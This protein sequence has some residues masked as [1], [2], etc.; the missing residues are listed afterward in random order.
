M[1]SAKARWSPSL[2]RLT[3]L[4][5]YA[6]AER[7]LAGAEAEDGGW[8]AKWNMVCFWF[9]SHSLLFRGKVPMGRNP[10][11]HGKNYYPH[12]GFEPGTKPRLPQNGKPAPRGQPIPVNRAKAASG[13]SVN[14]ASTTTGTSRNTE[15]VTR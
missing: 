3:R 2:K 13:R 1:I 5:S 4:A 14:L 6:A 7:K 11:C 10:Q 12:R 8:E 9:T 15:A